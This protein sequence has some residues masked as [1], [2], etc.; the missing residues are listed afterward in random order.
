MLQCHDNLTVSKLSQLQ[1]FILKAALGNLWNEASLAEPEPIFEEE[2]NMLN[3][4]EQL[5][6]ILRWGLLKEH[7]A[8]L[9]KTEILEGFFGFEPRWFEGKIYAARKGDFHQMR[10][11]LLRQRFDRKKI[12]LAKYQSAAASVIRALHRLEKRGL[13]EL[14]HGTNRHFSAI[15]LTE[16]GIAIAERLALPWLT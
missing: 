12:G 10:L 15:K 2:A 8:H 13:I 9:Y 3:G 1:R 14:F 16:S 7:F 5:R 11:W 6:Q 4:S